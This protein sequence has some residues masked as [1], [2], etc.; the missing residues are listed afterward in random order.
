MSGEK[1]R[2][3]SLELEEG[4]AF[5][6]SFFL[7]AQP[8]E[9]HLALVTGRHFRKRPM[10]AIDSSGVM[11]YSDSDYWSLLEILCQKEFR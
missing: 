6:M 4:A 8:D 11:D 2:A 3:A 7:Q 5:A 10:V 1:N 9:D